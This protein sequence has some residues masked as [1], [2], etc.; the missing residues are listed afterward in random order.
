MRRRLVLL[1][2]FLLAL[3][4]TGPILG[5]ALLRR[6]ESNPILR[7][8]ALARTLGC[9]GCHA[10][11]QAVEIPNPG[12]RWGTVPGF[13]GG[14]SAMYATTRKDLAEYVRFGAP[15]SWT[16]DADARKRLETQ[17]LR[18][19]AFG[20]VLSDREVDD[21]VAFAAAVGDFDLPGGERVEKGREIARAN[22]CLSC[23]GPEGAG[24]VA[25]PGSLAGFIPGFS[26][27]NFLDL[28]QGEAEFR[29]W[30]KTGTSARLEKNPV[31]VH[32]FKSQKIRMPAYA[33]ILKDEEIG[34]L[35]EWVKATRS[36]AEK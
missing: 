25:N 34:D 15:K 16:G 33:E 2:I 24:G 29:E 35:W 10:P 30:V 11:F 31:A 18:M 36:A 22:G 4:G 32:Y 23:H 5:R 1:G 20:D 9:V 7:G 19:P 12:S 27:G 13:A 3:V 6:R 21:L 28:V 26:G 17:H 14:N 8:A